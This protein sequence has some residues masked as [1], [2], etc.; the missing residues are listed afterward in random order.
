V[1]HICRFWF[2]VLIWFPGSQSF[3]AHLVGIGFFSS[4]VFTQVSSSFAVLLSQVTAR[5]FHPAVAPG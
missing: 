4:A 3:A 2:A 5:A 1:T